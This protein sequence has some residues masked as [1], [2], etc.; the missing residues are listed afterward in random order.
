[1]TGPSKPSHTA[2]LRQLF[3]RGKMAIALGGARLPLNQSASLTLASREDSMFRKRY[4][5]L[6]PFASDGGA[7]WIK[8]C[9]ALLLTAV[10]AAPAAAGSSAPEAGRQCRAFLG[11]TFEGATVTRATLIASDSG[12]SQACV[13]RAE[14]PRDLDFEV[15]MPVHWNHRTIFQGGGGFDGY[16][17]SPVQLAPSSDGNGGGYATISTNHGHNESTTPGA[18]FALDVEMLAEYAYLAVPR[19]LAPARTILRTW[20]GETFEKAKM[21]YEGCSG[22]G[23]QALIEAQRF[24][25]L[26]D[27]IIARAPANAYNPQFLWYHTVAARYAR[28]GGALTAGKADAIGQAVMAKCDALDGLNDGIIGRPDACKFDPA[29]LSCKGEETDT[30]LTPAQVATARAYYAPTSVANGRYL[31][32]GFMPGG[33]GARAWLLST[34]RYQ[35]PL[36][37]GY[38]KYLVTQ[39]P[40]IDPLQV[41]PARYTDRI[42]YLVSLIDAVDPDLRPFKARGGKV[43]LWTGTSDWLISANNA[44]AYYQSVVANSGGTAAADEFIEYYTAPSVQHCLGGTGA[45]LVDLA[46]PMFNWLE[47]GIKPSSTTII[48]SH[49]GAAAGA[50]PVTRPLCQYPKYPKYLGGDPNVAASFACSAP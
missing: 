13:I 23:R 31:W 35:N 18:S 5:S 15:R 25:D 48:A 30:C 1:M 36:D 6:A 49:R 9:L 28:P 12:S 40:D 32:P 38:I 2:P 8:A 41:D 33:E 24:P 37:V 4:R 10:W 16:V 46:G 20:Y 47:K 44:T 45:D 11:R 3:A 43:L 7:C 39:D 21:I 14:M 42:D 34:G 22:G 29:E 27:G 17:V 26:F 50:A 19:V